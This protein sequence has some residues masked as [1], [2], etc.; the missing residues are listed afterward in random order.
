MSFV[1]PGLKDIALSGVGTG[2]LGSAGYVKIPLI[3]DGTKQTFILQ[4]GLAAEGSQL[5]VTYPTAFPDR[6][7]L[8][9]ATPLTSFSAGVASVAM[10]N[11]GTLSLTQLNIIVARTLSGSQVAFARSVAWLALGY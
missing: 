4:W 1:N 11:V 2:L 5:T 6:V 9:L 8:A 3:I 7:A 10:A